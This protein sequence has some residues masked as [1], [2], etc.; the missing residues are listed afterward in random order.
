MTCSF[1]RFPTF[2]ECHALLSSLS[3]SLVCVEISPSSQPSTSAS[4]PLRSALLVGNETT[5]VEAAV[6]QL[7]SLTVRI[8]QWGQGSSLNVNVAASIVAYEYLRQHAREETPVVGCKY[9]QRQQ[10]Q[11]AEL[12]RTDSSERTMNLADASA[13][14]LQYDDER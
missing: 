9:G 2:A 8:P 12:I 1:S 7:A 13:L 5:G 10:Q 14:L 3:Y 6:L 4:F 11:A